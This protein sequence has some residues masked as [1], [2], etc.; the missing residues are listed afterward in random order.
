MRLTGL[1]FADTAAVIDAITGR[2]LADGV[3]RAIHAETEGNPLFVGEIVRLLEAEQSLERASEEPR[4]ALKLP[5]T[6]TEVIGQRLRRLSPDARALLSTASILGREFAVRDLAAL[7][8]A[9]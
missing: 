9:E 3:A 5:V 1:N 6:V 8:N 4:R 7:N 2:R